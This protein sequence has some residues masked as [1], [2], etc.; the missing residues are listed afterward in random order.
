MLFT[1]LALKISLR[2]TFFHISLISLG[3]Y[4]SQECL[5]NFLWLVG[6]YSTMCGKIVS[7]YDVHIPRKSTEFMHFYS[8]LSPPLKTP[9]RIFWK[10]V[11]PKTKGVEETMICF[12][13]I[14]SENMNM[15]WNITLF[16]FCMICI[17]S[18]C[19]GFTVL[20]IISIK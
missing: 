18:K 13:K 19:D 12:I 14:Q 3:F 10:S 7:I 4:L 16:I 1:T 20:W 15:T 9:G 8:C 2:D 11:S 6:L 5:L 17:F